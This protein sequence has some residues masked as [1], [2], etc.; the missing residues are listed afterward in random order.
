[1]RVHCAEMG[2]PVLGDNIYGRAP[3]V[4]GPPLHL[5]SRE[6]VVPI[7]KNKP[8]VAVTAPVPV[9]M[10]EALRRAVERER[11]AAWS[12]ERRGLQINT[13]PP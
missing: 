4:G 5:H 13:A 3:R 1:M 8:P 12:P 10:R 2:W 7:S 9:H 6:I 11:H